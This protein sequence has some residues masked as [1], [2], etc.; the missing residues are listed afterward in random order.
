MTDKEIREVILNELQAKG[1]LT[2]QELE[3][4]IMKECKITRGTFRV[5]LITL[6]M[7]DKIEWSNMDIVTSKRPQP[8]MYHI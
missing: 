4:T 7:N 1:Q 8:P 2:R 5:Q 6:E 3:D